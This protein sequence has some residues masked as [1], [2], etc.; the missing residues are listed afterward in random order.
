VLIGERGLVLQPLAHD[1]C[2]ELP[3]ARLVGNAYEQ[4][5]ALCVCVRICSPKLACGSNIPLSYL[6]C[7][8]YEMSIFVAYEVGTFESSRVESS[9][10]YAVGGWVV[11]QSTPRM[12]F[13][14]GLCLF[15][16]N[17]AIAE[18]RCLKN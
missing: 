5:F 1:A 4:C 13:R 17:G 11:R 12:I 3:G 18:M 8:N 2:D 16:E 7:E 10:S 6:T 9:Q 14:S 15:R